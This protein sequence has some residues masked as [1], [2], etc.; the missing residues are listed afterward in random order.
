[1]YLLRSAAR[2]NCFLG[3]KIEKTDWSITD[4]MKIIDNFGHQ[5]E[6]TWIVW[7]PFLP[8]IIRLERLIYM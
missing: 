3:N 2:E 1:M 7:M 5:M 8:H 4:W 6:T